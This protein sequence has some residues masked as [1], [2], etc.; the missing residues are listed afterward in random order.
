MPARRSSPKVGPVPAGFFRWP[1]GLQPSDDDAGFDRI[2][3]RPQRRWPAG[4]RA[5]GMEALPPGPPVRRLQLG[6]GGYLFALQR[7]PWVTRP[8]LTSFVWT[9][10][11]KGAGQ[12]RFTNQ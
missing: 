7:R 9:P 11:R 1:G 12:Q 3:I 10:W 8:P 4:G 5:R 6:S 2:V